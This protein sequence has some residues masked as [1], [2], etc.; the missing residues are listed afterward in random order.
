MDVWELRCWFKHKRFLE[1][2][3]TKELHEKVIKSRTAGPGSKQPLGTV[4]EMVRFIDPKSDTEV[5][6]IHRFRLPTGELGASGKEDPEYIVVDGVQFRR[7]TGPFEAKRDPCV[8]FPSFPGGGLRKVYGFFR[9]LCCR[10]LGPEYDGRLAAVMTPA[11][12]IALFFRDT[13]SR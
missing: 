5:A 12:R 6:E 8:L 7:F 3:Q 1:R 2:V 13:R 4:T 9:R 10:L 11:L